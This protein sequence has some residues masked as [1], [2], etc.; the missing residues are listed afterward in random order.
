MT[1]DPRT[2]TE[3]DVV[4]AVCDAL[5]KEGWRVD[6]RL[7]TT[8]RGVD[9]IARSG[10]VLLCVEAKGGTSSKTG[11]ARHGQ[12]FSRAQVA[13]HVARAFY[14]AAA[15]LAEAESIRSALAL[16]ETPD[17]HAFVERIREPL[18]RLGIGVFWV[19]SP[20]DVR[21]VAPWQL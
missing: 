7:E 19:R 4:A 11:T 18:D 3:N 8:E 10:S 2:L 20:R 14:T 15:A 1:R 6:Q 17:H 5:Q 12:P 16:P 13:S 9:V 21:L